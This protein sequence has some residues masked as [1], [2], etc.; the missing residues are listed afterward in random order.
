MQAR[1][2]DAARLGVALGLLALT[3]WSARVAEPTVI[4][5]NAFRLV[6]QLPLA[7]GAPLL[8]I[9][10]LG[11]L[12]AV[13]VLGA[14]A[15]L[16]RR[17]R[18]AQ[19]LLVGGAGAWAV[20]KLLEILVDQP[21]PELLLS[22]VT[23]HGVV[24]PGLAFPATHVAVAA[25]MATVAGPYL[26]RPNRR[27]AWWTVAV[28][29]VAR[30]YVGA[31]FPVDVIGGA[32]V[33][34]GLGSLLHLLAGAP[35]G[36]PG[37]PLL[38]SAAVALGL[39]VT[40]ERFLR[41]R[42]PGVASAVV[43]LD[44]G[45]RWVLKVIGRDQPEADWFYRA[46][47]LL[48]YRELDDIG[49][50]GSPVW[51]AE[52]EAYLLLLGERARLR[53]PRFGAS[54]PLG[55]GEAVVMREWVDGLSLAALALEKFTDDVLAELWRQVAAFHHLG[56]CLRG[57]TLHDLV[58]DESGEVWVIE[59]GAGRCD[60]T[61]DLCARDI[62]ELL[63]WL[64]LKLGPSRPLASVAAAFSNDELVC[65]LAALQPLTL[66]AQARRSVNRVGG[67]LNE[68]RAGVA[69]AAGQSPSPTSPPIRIAARNLVPVAALALA[70][71][72]L[73]PQVGQ[74]QATMTALGQGSWTWLL[75]VGVLSSTTY[76]MAA[77]ALIGAAG[78]RLAVGRTWA[79][80][81]AAAFTNRLVPAGL[82]GMGTNVRYL[83]AAGS[84][85][86]AAL[87]AVGL[88]SVAGFLVHLVGVLAIVPLLGATSTRLRVR[89]PDLPDNW[90]ILI[91]GLG[92][93]VVAGMIRWGATLHR[94]ASPSIRTAAASLLPILRRPGAAAALLG[95]SA[96]VTAGYTLALAASCRAF[97]VGLPLSTVAAVYLGG[98]AL[99][100][101]APTPGGLGA[102]EAA[103]VAGLIAAGAPSGPSVAAVLSYRLVTYWLPVIPGFVAYR[104]LRRSGAL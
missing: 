43:R 17:A 97:S 102:L 98:S 16:R 92:V 67:M 71:N 18:L 69:D 41:S 25:A 57:P 87:A 64:S 47:R 75:V 13:P 28:I 73:L 34:W 54:R 70:V 65:V 93:L 74:A 50:T 48:A 79:V 84:P 9:M 23:L 83:E 20:A 6:N 30:I 61:A 96:G 39:K 55:D 82:G 40:E 1:R 91:G 60:A 21:P 35:S 59:L 26:S 80:Q 56:V 49:G 58:L 8:G 14:V 89:G 38:N 99:A 46:W 2:G 90:P 19:L 22:K 29:G 104:V 66:S 63:V 27:L 72:L 36:Q 103:L 62:A 33:G 53:V 78:R 7:V 100:A 24:A 94:C 68:L 88:N 81:V 42:A 37:H 95:G 31:H 77:F 32:A 101:V 12:A 3:A 44:D 76:L 4:E 52:R 15:V 85:R 45:T 51:R 10:Q 5:V 86:P 11:A